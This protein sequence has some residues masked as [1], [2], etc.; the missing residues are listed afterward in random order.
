MPWFF[1]FITFLLISLGGVA[2]GL[3]SAEYFWDDDPGQGNGI[4]MQAAD[5]SFGDAIEEVLASDSG[6]MAA[7]LHTFNIRVQ[8]DVNNWGPV[9]STV[10]SI[11]PSI[12][13]VR[14]IQVTAGESFWDNDPG[15]G[16]GTAFLAFDGNFD[17]AMELM[18]NAGLAVPDVGVHTLNLR[19]RDA[20][21][22]WGP[23]FSTV[24]NVEPAISTVRDIQ[25]TAGE[26]FWDN[27]PGEGNGTAF[28][29]FDGNIDAAIEVMVNQTLDVPDVGVHLLNV[30][31]RDAENN[32]GPLFSMVVNIEPA[33]SSVREIKVTAAEYYFDTDPGPGNGT[34]MLA[35]NGNFNAALKAIKGGA[36]PQPVEAGVH[37]LWMRARDAESNWGPSFGVVVD[38]DTT[39]TGLIAQ[40]N[41]V[42]QL[43]ANEALLGIGYSANA[44]AGS[45][46]SWSVTNGA[47]VEG[48][49]TPNVVVNWNPSGARTLTLT[50]CLGEECDET[51]FTLV[52]NPIVQV[53]TDVSICNGASLFVGGGLQTQPGVYTDV[54]QSANGCDSTIVTTLSV[55]DAI[56]TLVSL[57][58]CSG[59]SVV[60]GGSAQST[61][62]VYT[63]TFI[64]AGGCDSLVVTTLT[65]AEPILVE[66]EA[67]V[68][69]GGSVFLAGDFQ[70]V[71]GDYTEVFTGANG[72]DSI[73]ITTLSVLSAP[74]INES[75]QICSGQ[76]IFLGGANQTEPG[77]YTDIESE[78]NGCETIVL[79]TLSIV[80]EIEVAVDAAICEGDSLFVGGA[81]QLLAGAYSDSF[82][83]SG[84]CDSVVVT[85]LSLLTPVFANES[86]SICSGDSLFVGGVFQ[87]AAG[88]YTDSF[89]AVNGCDSTLITELSVLDAPLPVIEFTGGVVTT[90]M[91]SSY[92]WFFNGELIAGAE[93]QFYLPQNEGE[94]VVFVTNV[95]G[96][97]GFSA[98]YFHLVDNVE[99][100]LLLT[101]NSVYPNPN[102]GRFVWTCHGCTNVR[103]PRVFDLNGRMVAAEVEQ[104]ENNWRIDMLGAAAGVYLVVAQT[105]QG[106][107]RKQVVIVP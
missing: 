51:S 20:E 79:T 61:S 52:V 17:A 72:C 84:G 32:W 27:D 82:V 76:S 83:S 80:D 91:F 71:P 16:N 69:Q 35:L 44:V 23:L 2:Q 73:V 60:L 11:E 29:A 4:A 75:V 96:C 70:S 22:N 5:G 49:G 1:S 66:A 28:V 47:I 42:T 40:I 95:N 89:I 65:V 46:Y 50:Q 87:F 6:L 58:I 102:D 77:I 9:F 3:L 81:W 45:T 101:H 14:A 26:S 85:N 103:L 56:E 24:V 63:D 59:E 74:Q 37:V 25:I 68:C 88:S 54:F 7:G 36:I 93:N 99:N 34:A 39:F 30:R 48:Q 21:N 19:V 57:E 12:A 18:V 43:C 94:Y 67:A 53:E 100:H 97:G 13:T 55:I 10:I 98:P 64:S 15:V 8:D 78:G 41:G 62:G 106:V 38:M 86:T 90:G 33:I 104:S 92:Q 107:M 31:V 105:D